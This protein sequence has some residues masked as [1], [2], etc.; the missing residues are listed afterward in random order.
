MKPLAPRIL[1][2]LLAPVS[3]RILGGLALTMAMA[4]PA[5]AEN[6]P[7]TPYGRIEGGYTFAFDTE[8]EGG[9]NT[10]VH[11]EGG[12]NI[13]GAAGVYIMPNTR[14]E[15]A[16]GYHSN[17]VDTASNGFT[18]RG[19]LNALSFMTTVIQDI[20]LGGGLR[21]F[22]GAGVG[23]VRLN[24]DFT[25][26]NGANSRAEAKDWNFAWTAT[27][28]IAQDINDHVSVETR[29][30]YINAGEYD[31]GSGP[32]GDYHNHALLAG[33]TMKF[34]GSGGSSYSSYQEPARP[35]PQ[36]MPEPEPMPEPVRAEPMP[37]A[38]VEVTPAEPRVME[39]IEMVFF[40]FNSAEITPTAGATLD[41]AARV[42]RDRGV[43]SIKLEGHTDTSGNADYNLR[44]SQ[45]RAEAV[46]QALM[47]R[48]VPGDNIELIAKGEGAPRVI[49]G[50]NVKT[51]SNRFVKIIADFSQ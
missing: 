15:V 30:R 47:V 43:R 4:V 28:G 12:Y 40:G 45:R 14:T 41:E 44:L 32:E 21:P 19:D 33:I 18:A 17:E 36:P 39:L 35:A 6:E 42:I 11:V 49:T 3:G 37:I 48:G 51:E 5:A 31:F 10:D 9:L 20:P 25:L 26:N 16:I 29:Y 7:G 23:A 34:G 50:D 22:V 1:S 46:R 38:P 8:V 27:A 2:R 13:G 24:P